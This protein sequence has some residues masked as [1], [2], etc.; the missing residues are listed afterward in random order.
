MGELADIYE[1]Q[2]LK[3]SPEE[4]LHFDSLAALK[5]TET[6]E[7]AFLKT[8]HVIESLLPNATQLD[9]NG[10]I[11]NILEAPDEFSMLV[12]SSDTGFVV[13][14]KSLI[15]DSYIDS[16]KQGNNPK[17]HGL[18]TS[19]ITNNN[20]GISP[21]QGK[22]VIYG[23]YDLKASDILRWDH[24]ISILILQIMVLNQQILRFLFPRIKCHQIRDAYIMN[25]FCQGLILSRLV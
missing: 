1:N 23:F 17:I 3:L 11:I 15:N 5:Y 20:L 24:M 7:K 2:L 6:Y 14:E 9:Y 8:K 25:L 13:D 21:V 18:A 22:G 16:W 10:K 12:H 4:M 19:F